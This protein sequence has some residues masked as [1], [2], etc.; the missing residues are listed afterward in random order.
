MNDARGHMI[1]TSPSGTATGKGGEIIVGDDLQNPEMAESE[2][3]RRNVIRFFDETLSTRLDDKRR[4]RIVVIQQRTHQAD[5]TGHLLEQGGWTLLCLP[6]E[7]ERR[8]VISLPRT[9]RS[10]VKQE[11]DLLWPEREG[12]AELIAARNRL[13]SFGY[14]SQYLQNPIARGGN[15]FLEKWFGT[16]REIPK[17]DAL[18]QSW[19]CAFKT[20]QTNDYSACVTIGRVDWTEG[21]SGTPPGYYLVHA[22]HGRIEFAEL[23]RH[24]LALYDLWHPTHVLIEDAASGQSL[25]QELRTT[26]LPISGVKPDGDKYARAASITP[27]MDGGHFWVL[28]GAPWSEDYLA[29]MTAFPG[30]AH[31]DFVDSTVQALTFLRQ[32]PEPGIIGHYRDLIIAA[33]T[34]A[35]DALDQGQEFIENYENTRMEIEAGYCRMCRT[36]LFQKS[37]V[38]DGLGYLCI[39][40]SRR[41]T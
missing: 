2:T 25:L 33:S 3:E 32:P 21:S 30:A 16:Y 5:L 10:I 23:K 11:G 40:C 15:L 26:L 9:G 7:F 35:V 14:A 19:D 8:T 27:A 4:G 38:S 1:A 34:G 13:G 37:S 28:E 6:A 17:F 39:A 20:G 31:D 29:E 24:A 22:W 41:S 12:R 36:N 18:V